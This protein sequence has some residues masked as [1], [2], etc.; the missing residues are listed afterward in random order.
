MNDYKKMGLLE[1]IIAHIKGDILCQVITEKEYYYLMFRCECDDDINLIKSMTIEEC[2]YYLDCCWYLGVEDT[3]KFELTFLKK[4]RKFHRTS[5]NDMLDKSIEILTAHAIYSD[6]FE[7]DGI[8]SGWLIVGG[9][10]SVIEEIRSW[11]R[12]S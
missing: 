3:E 8:K 9:V 11:R 12:L 5:H 10:E 6:N 7:L 1:K 4:Y 2:K